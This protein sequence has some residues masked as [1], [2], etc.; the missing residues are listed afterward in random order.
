MKQMFKSMLLMLVVNFS[1]CAQD[2]IQL[3][4]G[5][6]IVATIIELTE[7]NVRYR[8]IDE[9]DGPIRNIVY[10]KVEVIHYANGNKET[11]VLVEDLAT[12]KKEMRNDKPYYTKRRGPDRIPID[13][14]RILEGGL[15]V[16]FLPGVASDDGFS[17]NLIGLGARLGHKWYFGKGEMR[18]H[19]LQ[20]T[21]IRLSA[22]PKIE[23]DNTIHGAGIFSP[24][25]I[26]FTNAFKIKEKRGLE[27]NVSVAPVILESPAI[28]WSSG[29]FSAMFGFDVKY[30]HHR[31]A[32]GADISIAQLE[33]A[34][35]LT[36]VSLT[37]GFKF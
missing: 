2:T 35:N 21:W 19:G 12:V 23:E 4:D 28:G 24:L 25:G 34:R 27:V 37:T 1:A 18:R 22:Y 30:R 20:V 29:E 16:D 8:R 13:K 15:F 9:V 14:D 26:G 3:R 10:R 11:F 32:V 6:K 31:F 36:M 7:L 33:T 5:Q 17:T